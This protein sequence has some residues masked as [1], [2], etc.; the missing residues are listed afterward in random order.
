VT[1]FSSHRRRAFTL[2]ELLVVIC[3]IAVLV[4][5]TLPSLPGLTRAADVNKAVSGIPLFLDESRAYAMAHNTYVWVGFAEEAGTHRLLLGC[6]A[7]TTG[8][9]DDLD[10]Q[11]IAPISPLR[12]YERFALRAVSGLVG[13]AESG[14]DIGGSRLGTFSQRSGTASATFDKVLRYSPRGEAAIRPASAGGS[15]RWIRIGLQ[16]VH[17]PAGEAEGTDVAVLQVGALTGQVEVFR[18]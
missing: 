5:V 3:I 17:G 8:Q 4:A 18:P 11:N 2:V 1:S 7:G 9:A 16:P 10:T 14:D 12:S 13:M 6:V 15:S